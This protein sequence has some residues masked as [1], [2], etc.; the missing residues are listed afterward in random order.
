M[1]DGQ[2]SHD[3]VIRCLSQAEQGSKELWGYVKS[4]VREA[5]N[6]DGALI[7]DDTIEEKPYTDENGIVCWHH[8]HT[9]GCHVKGINLLTSLV[10]YEDITFPIGFEI[11]KKDLK[12]WDEKAQREKRRASV[13]KNGL[14]EKLVHQ[15]V[16]NNVKF[17]WVLADSWYGTT[18]NMNLIHD[19]LRKYFIFGIKSNR[20]VAL[21]LEA[22]LS[23]HFQSVESLDF[24]DGECK[25]VYLR[26]TTPPVQ[27]LKKVFTN[28]DGSTGTLY[29]VTNDLTVAADHLYDI[30]KRR[31]RI[32][33]FHKSV[34]QNAS[35]AK[36]PTKVERTQRNHIFA[37]M[38]A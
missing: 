19:K 25:T 1:L 3:K 24:K 32:E 7:L 10:R 5:E 34:K 4:G 14:F 36:F 21:S 18:G 12:Y 16:R 6:D 2:I 23:G 29:L 27:L 8:S 38:I 37:S 31:W 22:K 11:I 28:K 17:K 30:Y 13:G 26:G 35:L 15:A 9:K 33:E 20:H